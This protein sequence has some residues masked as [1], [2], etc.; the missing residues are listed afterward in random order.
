MTEI[1]TRYETD[2]MPMLSRFIFKSLIFL[3]NSADYLLTRLM[4]ML[5]LLGSYFLFPPC[6]PFYSVRCF[7]N[8]SSILWLFAISAFQSS[9]LPVPVSSLF[10]LC[11]LLRLPKP[12]PFP[13]LH[14]FPPGSLSLNRRLTPEGCGLL[15]ALLVLRVGNCVLC[16]WISP[17]PCTTWTLGCKHG[18]H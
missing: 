11:R 10:N 5:A 12:L 1:H 7:S 6:V 2:I 17:V 16:R 13:T 4:K 9:A 14:L 15:R 3:E 8:T 18:A